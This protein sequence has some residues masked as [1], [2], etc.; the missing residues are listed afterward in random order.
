MPLTCGAMG[1]RTPDL[2]HA[3]LGGSV[4]HRGSESDT[5][6]SGRAGLSGSVGPSLVLHEAVVTWLVT[7]GTEARAS[8]RAVARAP[9][10]HA[11]GDLHGPVTKPRAM[12][13]TVPPSASI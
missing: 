13:S 4:R 5:G 3:M 10:H 9:A 11:S 6:R 2:L 12:K 7:A 8:V 1:I